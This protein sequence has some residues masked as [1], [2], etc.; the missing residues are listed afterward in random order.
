MKKRIDITVESHEILVLRRSSAPIHAWCAQCGSQ[1]QMIPSA[2]AALLAGVSSRVIYRQIEAGRLHF[3]E[4]PDHALLICLQSLA[5][6]IG[7]FERE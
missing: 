2:Q 3:I 7:H 1:V 4:T 5:A 6:E